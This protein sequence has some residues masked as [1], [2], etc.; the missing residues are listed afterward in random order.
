M[1]PFWLPIV[2]LF[3][4]SFL[5]AARMIKRAS[6]RGIQ[7]YQRVTL[8][9]MLS[10]LL[11]VMFL[12]YYSG[13]VNPGLLLWVP[14]VL[15]LAHAA[16]RPL[17]S[18]EHLQSFALDTVHCGRCEYDLTGNVS[19]VCPECGWVIPRGPVAVEPLNWAFWW[20]GWKVP[21]LNN[22]RRTLMWTLVLTTAFAALAAWMA[23][24][25]NAL[26]ILPALMCLHFVINAIRLVRYGRRTERPFPPAR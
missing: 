1:I 21:H 16:F 14:F 22:W 2:V 23:Y 20:Q 5:I 25:K 7:R 11:V 19:G 17:T 4:V 10:L 24:G 13:R 26:A 18:R 12:Q 9:Y 6:P 3:V 8:Y 15:I